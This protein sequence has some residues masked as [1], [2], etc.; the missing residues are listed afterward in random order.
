MSAAQPVQ[1]D[2]AAHRYTV[3]GRHVIN[4]TSVLSFYNAELDHVAPEML[5]RARE[6]GTYVHKACELDDLSTLNEA[7]LDPL[8]EPYLRAWRRFKVDTG[9]E[10]LAIEE[11]VYHRLYDYAGTLDRRARL[12]RLDRYRWLLDVKSGAK[13]RW[14]GPQTGAYAQAHE[15]MGGEPIE[16]RAAIY[17]HDDGTYDLQPHRDP[18]DRTTFL[19]ALTLYR[20]LTAGK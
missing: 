14:A 6:L 7:E 2:P 11:R 9:F 3:A 18:N 15:A 16:R 4:V 10:C 8:L 12:P 5:E 13:S 1:F 19:S 17:L 20:W